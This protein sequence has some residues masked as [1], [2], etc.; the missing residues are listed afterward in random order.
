MKVS[1]EALMFYQEKLKKLN[2]EMTHT[3]DSVT[4]VRQYLRRTTSGIETSIV[5]LN[6]PLLVMGEQ[7]EALQHLEQ[8]L[9]YVISFYRKCEKANRDI[10]EKNR[11]AHGTK[12]REVI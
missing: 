6:E 1:I 12:K 10:A 2:K 4:A 5:S 3:L 8:V 11:T 9:D 7:I